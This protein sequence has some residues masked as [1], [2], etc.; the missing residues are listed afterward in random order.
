MKLT[1]TALLTLAAHL[2]LTSAGPAPTAAEECGPLGVMSST[3]AATKAG[4]S[5]AD[6]RKCKEHPLSLVSPRDTAADAT[7]ATVF[8]RDC[9]WGDNYGCTDGYCWEKCNPEKGHWCWTAWGDGFGD[10]RKCKGKGECE[11]VK[12]AACG[13]GN[14]EKCGCSC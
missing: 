10:W 3:D 13:Q 9:W 6:I 8:A 11:P 12:N 2:S 4:I 1:T 7:D 5:P 14:C